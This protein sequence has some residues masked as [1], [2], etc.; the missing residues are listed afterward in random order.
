MERRREAT[1][2]AP[3]DTNFESPV[4]AASERPRRGGAEGVGAAAGSVRLGLAWQRSELGRRLAVSR[5]RF[6]RRRDPEDQRLIERPADE[7]DADG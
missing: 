4:C 5:R 6:V 2:C 1:T 7:I 3:A